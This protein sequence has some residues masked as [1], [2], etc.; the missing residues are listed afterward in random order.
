MHMRACAFGAMHLHACLRVYAR[1]SLPILGMPVHVRSYTKLR[2]AR[3]HMFYCCA[4]GHALLNAGVLCIRTLVHIRAR[5]CFDAVH[6]RVRAR[7]RACTRALLGAGVL[8][9]RACWCVRVRMLSEA[10]HARARACAF[11][12]VCS[13]CS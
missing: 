9:I 2:C 8:C 10:V 12:Q 1:V 7:A 13:A 4:G 5:V 3:S 6:V 11:E